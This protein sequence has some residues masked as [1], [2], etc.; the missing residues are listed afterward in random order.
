MRLSDDKIDHLA[1]VVLQRLLA[2]EDEDDSIMVMGEDGEIR[3]S[4]RHALIDFLRRDEQ[5]HDRVRRK[6]ASMKRGIPEG[7]AEWDALY[8]Q[9]LREEMEKV[10]KVR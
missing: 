1:D 9:F 7:S 2:L 3:A 4:I 8:S 5:I 10:R 6:I